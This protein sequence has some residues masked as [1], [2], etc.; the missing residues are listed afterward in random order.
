MWKNRNVWIVLIGE[1]GAGIGLW[2]GI[3]GNLDFMQQHVPSDFFKSLILFFGLLAGVFVGPLAGRLI[4]Q[5]PKKKILL[6]SG[7]GR[8]ISILVMFIA[9]QYESIIFMV[10]FLIFLQ[11]SAAFYFPALQAVIP[12][13]V[14]D[15]QLLTLNGIH[16]NV[17]TIAR[18]AG[19]SVGGILVVATSLT[20]VYGISMLAYG[21]LFIMTFFL[22]FEEHK[23]QNQPE[24]KSN[25]SKKKEKGFSEIFSL[26]KK[27]PSVLNLFILNIIPLLFIGGFNLMVIEISDL[28]HD[29][30][31]KG[32]I[33]TFEGISFMLG[34]FVIKRLTK[35][36]SNKQ[37]LYFFTTVVAVAQLT[38]FFADKHWMSLMS[39]ALFGFG[40]GCFFPVSST[41]F[42]TSID[43]SFHGRLFSFRSMFD[44]V[45]FQIVLLSTGL[46]LDTIGLKYMVLIFG[47]VSLIIIARL[48]MKD[49]RNKQELL[50]TPQ[51]ISI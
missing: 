38:L 34:A 43:K 18:I 1:F 19:T 51:N 49:R 14:K 16:M 48:I 21:F 36:F 10:L 7:L 17:S 23:V 26:I 46:F 11:I 42:Q 28:Q 33:Y 22:Q 12:L 4:D 39:F 2:V 13:I 29:P 9:I 25:H 41:V 6:V 3:I 20:N 50:E 30:S 15:D 5:Y 45:M 44:R 31:I 40:V 37:L 47:T 24:L 8:T 32:L 27:S 35:K